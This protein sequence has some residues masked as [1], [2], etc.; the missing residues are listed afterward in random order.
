MAGETERKTE[1]STLT[2]KILS[3]WQSC[4]LLRNWVLIF[5]IFFLF[6]IRV[7][8][9]ITGYTLKTARNFPLA[10]MQGASPC[11]QVVFLIL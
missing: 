1:V 2:K 5:L 10:A 3:I 6:Y 4:I 11:A 7:Y 9:C 8:L